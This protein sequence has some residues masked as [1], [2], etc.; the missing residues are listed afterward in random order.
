MRRV[1]TPFCAMVAAFGLSPAWA[2]EAAEAAP[3][4]NPC[5][6]K[7]PNISDSAYWAVTAVELF[8][9]EKY[10]DAVT[11]VNACF[12]L[13]GPT[14]GQQQKK[15]HDEGARCPPTG[16]VNN[17]EKKKIDRNGLL[18]DV[19]MALWAKARSLHELDDIEPAKQAYARC[20]YMACGRAWDPQGWF[21]SPAE[22]CAEKAKALVSTP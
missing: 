10:A 15:L 3:S 16:E 8:A 17:W 20:I 6:S 2:D 5:I 4:D 14:A 7:D 21:W 11:T 19:A 22:D 13:W 9:E 18:N 12:S 1:V